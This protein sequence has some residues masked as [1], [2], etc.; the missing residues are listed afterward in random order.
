MTEIELRQKLEEIGITFSYE[1]G[2]C[3]I[4]K[5]ADIYNVC[6]IEDR[7]SFDNIV[8]LPELLNHEFRSLNDLKE[9]IRSEIYPD[10]TDERFAQIQKRIDLR[11]FDWPSAYHVAC[12][13]IRVEK[14]REEFIC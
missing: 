5:I 2:R 1:P 11:C 7:R 9:T 14:L 8:W 10:L 12:Q 13:D 4:R 3:P 6:I